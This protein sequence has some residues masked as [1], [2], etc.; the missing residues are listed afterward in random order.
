MAMSLPQ[1]SSWDMFGMLAGG[2][3]L[4]RVGPVMSVPQQSRMSIPG[5]F[6]RLF[7]SSGSE[8]IGRSQCFCEKIGMLS[9]AV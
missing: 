5:E 6:P 3:V 1:Q 8:L 4:E 2:D 9:N 7:G